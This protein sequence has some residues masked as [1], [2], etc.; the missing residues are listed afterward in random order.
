M[1]FTLIIQAAG[2]FFIASPVIMVVCGVA[3]LVSDYR[4]NKS[5]GR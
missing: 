1:F 5:I 3:T 4:F 2:Y